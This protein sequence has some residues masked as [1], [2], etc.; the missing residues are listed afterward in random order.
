MG[1]P[2][3]WRDK[4]RTTGRRPGESGMVRLAG[5]GVTRESWLE[6]GGGRRGQGRVAGETNWLQRA[7]HLSEIPWT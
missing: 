3:L 1:P 4:V 5:V 6:G 7:E 2:A